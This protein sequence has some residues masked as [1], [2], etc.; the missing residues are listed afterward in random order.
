MKE[1]TDLFVT[2][3]HGFATISRREIDRLGHLT[4]SES[5]QHYYLDNNGK[6]ETEKGT[7]PTGFLAIDLAI[8]LKTG[9]FDPDR[10]ST[11]GRAPY[12]KLRLEFD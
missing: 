2:S 11:E 12:K 10:H 8:G 4:K 9:L 3:D 6:V 7:L 1:N 5:A